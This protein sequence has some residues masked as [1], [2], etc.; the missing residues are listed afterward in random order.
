MELR[1]FHGEQA[2]A[3]RDGRVIGGY[4]RPLTAEIQPPYNNGDYEQRRKHRE[5][6]SLLHAVAR[7]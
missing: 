2:N 7:R 4:Y 3:L 5:L 1:I 6:S